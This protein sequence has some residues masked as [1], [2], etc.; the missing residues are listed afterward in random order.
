[1]N[2]F[3]MFTLKKMEGKLSEKER[4]RQEKSPAIKFLGGNV[5]GL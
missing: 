1:M 5:K 2:T 3:G 4:A